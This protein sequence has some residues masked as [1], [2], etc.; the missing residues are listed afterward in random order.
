MI[1]LHL[2]S[3]ES[4]LFESDFFMFQKRVFAVKPAQEGESFCTIMNFF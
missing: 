2:E 1:V 3:F 4:N